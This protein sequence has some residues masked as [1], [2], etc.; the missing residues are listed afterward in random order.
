MAHYETFEMNSSVPLEKFEWDDIWFDHATDA[1]SK[2]I[3]V[4]GDSISVN[5]RFSLIE[6]LRGK[7]C[8][9]NYGTSVRACPV[10]GVH[11]PAEG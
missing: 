11:L 2:R 10:C 5:Y 3:I 7:Y 9:D 4:F 6:E 8:V 1:E